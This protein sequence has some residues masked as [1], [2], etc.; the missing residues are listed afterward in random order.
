MVNLMSLT[1]TASFS[2]NDMQRLELHEFSMMCAHGKAQQQ[3]FAKG[4]GGTALQI[5]AMRYDRIRLNLFSHPRT[6]LRERKLR[7]ETH[8]KLLF[9]IMVPHVSMPPLVSTH[10]LHG[11]PSLPLLSFA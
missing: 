2:R 11:N 7:I 1:F 5:T 4:C 10:D 6:R 3:V 8:F 9:A